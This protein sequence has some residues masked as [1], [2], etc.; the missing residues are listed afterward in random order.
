M[1]LRNDTYTTYLKKEYR[2]WNNQGLANLVSNDE[3]DLSNGFIE[4]DPDGNNNPRIF[5]K[6][7]PPSEI[8]DVYEI[9][10]FAIY[11]GFEFYVLN[12]YDGKYTLSTIDKVF[13][14]KLGFF[15]YEF[16]VFHKEVSKEDLDLIFEKKKL[17]E[18][19]FD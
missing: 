16:G 11:K 2:V 17:I 9:S 14:E 18:N 4:Y 10:T 12:E 1:K 7:V 13:V 5:I 19:F 8:G 15:Q 6:M 3:S